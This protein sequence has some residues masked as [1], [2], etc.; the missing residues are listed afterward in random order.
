MA[1][2]SINP[3]QLSYTEFLEA[4]RLELNNNPKQTI[5]DLTQRVVKEQQAAPWSTAFR[6]AWQG[7]NHHTVILESLLQLCNSQDSTRALGAILLLSAIDKT[8]DYNTELLDILI[9]KTQ[10]EYK[11]L[12]LF[13]LYNILHKYWSNSMFSE[14]K[15]L[16]S[17]LADDTD[18]RYTVNDLH[19]FYEVPFADIFKS[20]AEGNNK[21]FEHFKYFVKSANIRLSRIVGV[22]YSIY[23][24]SGTQQR[25]TLINY[26]DQLVTEKVNEERIA[27]FIS[28]VLGNNLMYR[29]YLNYTKPALVSEKLRFVAFRTSNEIVKRSIQRSVFNY[30]ST[31]DD[32][33]SIAARG[34]FTKLS[35]E[36]KLE[37]LDIYE[38]HKKDFPVEPELIPED[39]SFNNK[40]ED[41]AFFLRNKTVGH[42]VPVKLD[43][44]IGDFSVPIEHIWSEDDFDGCLLR[45]E[46]LF[47]PVIIINENRW[48]ETRIRFTLA[49]ELSH[50]LLPE[51]MEYGGFCLSEWEKPDK[52]WRTVERE[53]DSLAAAILMPLQKVRDDI[54]KRLTPWEHIENLSNKYQ[55]SKMAFIVRALTVI[56]NPPT[57]FLKFRDGRCDF[58]WFSK[59]FPIGYDYFLSY[60]DNCPSGSGANSIFTGNTDKVEKDSSLELWLV[61]EL[62]DKNYKVSEYS[63]KYGD[64]WVLTIL[65]LYGGKDGYYDD[66]FEEE[67]HNKYLKSQKKFGFNTFYSD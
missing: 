16:L 19:N 9:N 60:G 51:H 56:D 22:F 29:E 23:K 67:E 64:S 2:N 26:T 25:K 44:I 30:S 50:Y 47:V 65:E 40:I 17:S 11:E 3:A 27:D 4:I 12:R 43:E 14:V 45:A 35:D 55:V 32:I 62:K 5:I 37:L 41:I 31:S 28:Q 52:K 66:D 21:S 46:G 33:K 57:V 24:K 59:D 36:T 58:R 48:P 34:S 13:I 63:I 8:Y 7:S 61:S 18:L 15:E 6:E 20:M 42:D 10:P 53:A 38:R 1:I 54:R 49:H 39:F